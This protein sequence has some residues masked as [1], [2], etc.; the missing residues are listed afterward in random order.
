MYHRR[1][2]RGARDVLISLRLAL[3]HHRGGV[4]EEGDEEHD[5]DAATFFKLMLGNLG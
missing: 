1:G 4:E 5:N 2:T 3:L